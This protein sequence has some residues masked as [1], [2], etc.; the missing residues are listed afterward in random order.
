MTGPSHPPNR[1]VRA[2]ITKAFSINGKHKSPDEASAV[3]EDVRR[4]DGGRCS[5]TRR[6]W[7][8]RSDT[9]LSFN[10]CL[11]R[12]YQMYGIFRVRQA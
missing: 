5:S 3:K 7:L 4:G 12:P 2:D 1:K 11:V 6:T 9:V 8:T 10:A